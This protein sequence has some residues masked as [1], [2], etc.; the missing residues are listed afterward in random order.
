MEVCCYVCC[1]E[2]QL[3]SGLSRLY[4]LQWGFSFLISLHR[5]P[6]CTRCSRV[7]YPWD[8]GL[9]KRYGTHVCNVLSVVSLR[10]FFFGS[11]LHLQHFKTATN[12]SLILD[13]LVCLTNWSAKSVELF[14]RCWYSWH[15]LVSYTYWKGEKYRVYHKL[16]WP[17]RSII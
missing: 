15:S 7:W 5:H 11:V 17:Q 6:I 1:H 8:Q 16:N 2:A 13:F 3:L 10:L 9:F 14:C 4:C 12:H